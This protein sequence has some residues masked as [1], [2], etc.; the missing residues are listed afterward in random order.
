MNFELSDEQSVVSDLASRIIADHATTARVKAVEAAD[1]FDRDLWNAIA[2][3][4]LLGLCLPEADGGSGMGMVELA[5]IA[6]AQGRHVA[7]VPVVP[8]IATAITI[9]QHGSAELRAAVLPGVIDG[10]AVLSSA[11]AESGANDVRTTTVRFAQSANGYRLTGY[12]PAVPYGNHAAWVLVPAHDGLGTI[13]LFA[14]NTADA[15]VTVEAAVTTDRQAAAHLTLDTEVPEWARLGN[16]DTLT[17]LVLAFTT[18]WCG[19]HLGVAE[20]ALAIT[21]DHVRTRN[22]FGKPLSSFQ[23]VGQRAADG[24]ITTEALRVTTMNAAWRLAEQLPAAHDVLVAAYWAS[25][26]GQQVTLA[27]QHL[28]GGI[29]AD[30]DY[31]VHRYFQWSSQLANTLGTASSH[32]ARLGTMLADDA[33]RRVS[34]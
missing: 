1:G 14:V 30:I 26:G 25:E 21:A 7:P 34:R 23:A 19:V 27:C 8:C 12:K 33:H 31:P 32:L 10:S 28:H 3:A 9:A 20:G 24:Y 17:E 16:A 2:D 6:E 22:Q 15:G 4:G 18:G 5:L 13:A 29:G 11:L